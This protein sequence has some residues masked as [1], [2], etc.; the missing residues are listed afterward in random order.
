MFCDMFDI[1]GLAVQ[2]VGNPAIYV[3]ED[4]RL[5]DFPILRD[6]C[7]KLEKISGFHLEEEILVGGLI[8]FE[9]Q[10]V[11]NKI[12]LIASESVYVEHGIYFRSY[13]KD[14]NVI[15]SNQE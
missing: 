10:S 15:R 6:L 12:M 9:D 2:R 7:S 13:D 8:F 1:V 5:E 3:R 11:V 14:G 4:I